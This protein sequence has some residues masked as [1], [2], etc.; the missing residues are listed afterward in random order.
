[1]VIQA[2]QAAGTLQH[3]VIGMP[4]GNP[5]FLPNAGQ[6]DMPNWHSHKIAELNLYILEIEVESWK[7]SSGLRS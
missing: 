3:S 7:Y 6:Y 4:A 1:L 5:V 2:G